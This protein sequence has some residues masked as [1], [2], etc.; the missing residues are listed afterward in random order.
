M[1]RWLLL[2]GGPLIWA[3]HF[4]LIYAIASIS[5]QASGETGMLARALVVGS[6]VV[7][8]FAAIGV[9]LLAWRRQGEEPFDRFFRAVS[10]AG[11]VLAAIAICWQTLP[12]LAPI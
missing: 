3:G 5:I 4:G 1:R 10:A 9:L 8:V 2:L 11:A 6:T 12:V 7:A